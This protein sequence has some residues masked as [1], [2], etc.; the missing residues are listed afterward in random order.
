MSSNESFWLFDVLTARSP[1]F[2]VE[3]LKPACKPLAPG[4]CN[5]LE[6][7]RRAAQA[8]VGRQLASL[9]PHCHL[10]TVLLRQLGVGRQL[11]LELLLEDR[12]SGA[13]VWLSLALGIADILAVL[14]EVQFDVGVAELDRQLASLL[15][16]DKQGACVVPRVLGL[17][18]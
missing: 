4:L 3:Q 7:E 6:R 8:V 12:V 11:E 10:H 15:D 1:C 2:L 14:A 18:S 16:S 13:L 9:V 17:Q 5:V